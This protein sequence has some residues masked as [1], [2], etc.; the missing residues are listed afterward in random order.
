MMVTMRW[1]AEGFDADLQDWC[2]ACGEP[3][4]PG[5]AHENPIWTSGDGRDI[6]DEPLSS[7][8]DAE[9]ERH[10]PQ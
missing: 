10:E 6:P 4:V 8:N 1:K 5:P 9:H 7:A 3:L 2:Y